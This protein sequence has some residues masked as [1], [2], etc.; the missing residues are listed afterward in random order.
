MVAIAGLTSNA[1]SRLEDLMQ[2]ALPISAD[3]A[4]QDALARLSAAVDKAGEDIAAQS[5]IAA[6]LVSNV[7][8]RYIPGVG[9]SEGF[10]T[11][12]AEL[13]AHATDIREAD[14]IPG[15]YPYRVTIFKFADD[16]HAFIPDDNSECVALPLILKK[17][18]IFVP[19]DLVGDRIPRVY[20]SKSDLIR[21]TKPTILKYGVQ[22]RSEGTKKTYK[23]QWKTWVAFTVEH[24]LNILPAD[25][26]E[27][28][29]WLTARA[30]AQA[31]YSTINLGL[32]AVKSI[33]LY[34]DQPHPCDDLV[35]K[36]LSGIRRDLG[37]AQAQVSG[38]DPAGIA[39]I[40]ATACTPRI[41]RGG[42]METTD[43]ARK[44]GYL[45]IAII[46]V[47]FDAMLRVGELSVLMWTDFTIDPDDSSG[48]LYIALS[49]TDRAGEGVY[50]YISSETVAALERIKG[51]ARPNDR[52]FPLSV[53]TL[54]RHIT[55]AAAAAGLEGR[56][57]GHSGRVGMA[58]TLAA[59]DYQLPAI[60]TAGRWKSK[61]MPTRYT[62]LQTPKQS[63]VARLDKKLKEA[64]K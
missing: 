32:Q 38:L 26:S 18:C 36:T 16:S 47:S 46:R 31:S 28:A 60:Q 25:P 33:H 48:L 1:S 57:S 34:Y 8:S 14:A 5:S 21:D 43:Y 20:A 42:K 27:F 10:V 59:K 58:Q 2:K 54:R 63:A 4:V 44:R 30:R 3:P 22:S 15:V 7:H 51:T 11:A 24:G 52:I 23:L 64:R 19:D 41:T 40:E 13:Y 37:V 17:R 61:A 55:A 62:R 9:P 6:E 39:A 35:M 12:R 49:K 53:R 45:D 50:A 56:F 29:E